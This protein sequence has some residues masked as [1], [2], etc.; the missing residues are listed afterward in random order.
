MFVIFLVSPTSASGKS[1][2]SGSAVS[3]YGTATSMA[4]IILITCAAIVVKTTSA[5]AHFRARC[6]DISI[7]CAV[8]FVHVGHIYY[9]VPMID[10][11]WTAGCVR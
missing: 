8:Y 9:D 6:A 10:S 7:P 1:K 2:S 3:I 5:C 4:V 11:G